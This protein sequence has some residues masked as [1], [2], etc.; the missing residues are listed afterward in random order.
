MKKK[1]VKQKSMKNHI[2]KS[3]VEWKSKSRSK[4]KPHNKKTKRSSK[5]SE[6]DSRRDFN[7]FKGN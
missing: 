7:P 3:K 1:N 4:N 2:N 6:D 5:I